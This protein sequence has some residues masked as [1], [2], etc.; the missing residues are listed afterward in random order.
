MVAT[1]RRAEAALERVAHH[2]TPARRGRIDPESGTL[3]FQRPIKVVIAHAGFYERIAQR[4]VDFEHAIHALQVEHDAALHARRRPSIC[5]VASRRYA[6]HP[7]PKPVR[8]GEHRP[9]LRDARRHDDSRRFEAACIAWSER[10]QV[11]LYRAVRGKNGVTTHDRREGSERLL[12]VG[13]R[14]SGWKRRA[15]HVSGTRT[16][17]LQALRAINSRR[18]SKS[19]P[20]KTRHRCHRSGIRQA[21]W[22]EQRVTALRYVRVSLR[23]SAWLRA[24]TAV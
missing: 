5:V 21:E 14:N 15:A 20:T 3:G 23:V 22:R 2:A 24:S 11:R 19:I 4:F 9:D 12:E 10:V 6:P 17:S 18:C 13:R 8:H 7:H 16:P 1:R